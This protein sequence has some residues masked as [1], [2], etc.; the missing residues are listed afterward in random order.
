[1]TVGVTGVWRSC[2]VTGS[3][4]DGAV[5]RAWQYPDRCLVTLC[6]KCHRHVH[7]MRHVRFTL[8]L[9]LLVAVAILL[10]MK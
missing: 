10:R 5:P 2:A 3:A 7:L 8:W 1:M 9:I 4:A 6:Q